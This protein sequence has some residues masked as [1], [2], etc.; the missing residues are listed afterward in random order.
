MS[1]KQNY[2]ATNLYLAYTIWSEII[3]G[4]TSN[5]I[6][7]FDLGNSLTQISDND[8]IVNPAV[9]RDFFIFTR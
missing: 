9:K 1:K 3:G 2:P 6:K 5:A 8:I 4:H 7:F